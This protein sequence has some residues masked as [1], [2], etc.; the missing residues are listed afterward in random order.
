MLIATDASF[1]LFNMRIID[2]F[3]IHGQ[4]G[5]SMYASSGDNDL[6]RRITVEV[7]WKLGGFNCNPRRQ[8]EHLNT[9]V[10]KGGVNPFV[11][12]AMKYQF[13]EFNK[14]RHF[15][16]RKYADAQSFIFIGQKMFPKFW[17]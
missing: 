11:D 4:Q 6:I 2:N 8:I 9:W 14:F 10:I 16:T 13:F 3:F 1:N 15:P 5:A 17:R 12:W 7:S